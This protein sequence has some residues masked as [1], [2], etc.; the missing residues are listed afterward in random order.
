MS[1]KFKFK[2][3]DPNLRL[4]ITSVLLAM[5]LW[6]MVNN[7]SDPAIR[8]TVNNVS[9]QIQHGE[10]I[11]GRGDVY[12][13]LDN[14]DV[15]PV[16][17][18]QA[19]RS[20]IDKLEAKN[21]IATADLRDMEEDG[22]VRI[23]LT[24]D[25]YSSSIE[26]ISGSIS[27]LLLRVEPSKTKSLALE[28]DAEGSPADGYM[29]YEATAEQ[30]QV[31]LSGPESYVDEVARAVVKVDI[32]N[33]DKSINSYPD[34][35][36]YDHDGDLITA[37]DMETHKLHLNISSVRVFASIYQTKNVLIS[38]GREVPLADGYE[39]ES[40]PAVEPSSIRIAGAAN[41][42]R[43]VYI[44]EIPAED[45]TSEPVST[46]IHK[47]IDLT[48]YLPEGIVLADEGT[49]S[50]TVYVQVVKT[51]NEDDEKTSKEES[52][53]EDTQE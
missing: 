14:T 28:V 33:A 1:K 40:D 10:V 49:G 32:D 7:F 48:K 26:R 47:Q 24:T 31:N 38:C 16:V 52:S 39:L 22:S 37:E 43:N 42:L 46:N 53:G 15:I 23:I 12:T 44:I 34:I 51:Q 9:V 4:K 5:A 11:E 36:L 41:T 13:V 30:N 8:M 18:L 3:L 17:T 21:V 20:V 45:I 35:V 2:E 27:N 6:Y 25:K 19:K 50:V 29:L